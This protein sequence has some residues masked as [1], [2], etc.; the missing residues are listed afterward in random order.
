MPREFSGLK[1]LA[2][3]GRGHLGIVY[4][5]VDLRCNREV[6]LKVLIAGSASEQDL[7]ARRFLREARAMASLVSD[8]NIPAIYAVGEEL[9]QPY[10]I[11]EFVDGLTLQNGVL[12]GLITAAE[13]VRICGTIAG[14][15]ER[16]HQCG[17]AHRNLTPENILIA[18]DGVPKLIGFS[19][20][21][22]LDAQLAGRDS[23][24]LKDV[25]S[26]QLMLDWLF[27]TAKEPWPSSLESVHHST[28]VRSADELEERLAVIE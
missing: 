18:R 24:A 13:G 28:P 2:E 1:I 12:V 25:Q 3:V 4:R 5:A 11:R 26:L 22:V 6:G 20:V 15:L 23:D 8:P 14:A 10:L 27:T 7:R 16:I 21:G 9:G 19:R 17:L